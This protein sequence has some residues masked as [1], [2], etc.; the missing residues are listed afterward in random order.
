MILQA[1][2]PAPSHHQISIIHLGAPVSDLD[3]PGETGYYSAPFLT[4]EDKGVAVKKPSARAL[5]GAVK[6]PQGLL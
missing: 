6:N 2:K 4:V 5:K 1:H 3:T